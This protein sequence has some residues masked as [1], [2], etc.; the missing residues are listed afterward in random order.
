M[1]ISPEI[2]NL[3]NQG[4]LPPVQAIVR[5]GTLLNLG[6]SAMKIALNALLVMCA[7]ALPAWADSTSTAPATPPATTAPAAPTHPPVIAARLA[8]PVHVDGVLSEAVWQ[9]GNAVTQ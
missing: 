8:E 4:A 9:N 1:G 2:D 6:R 5:L 7:F 3:S